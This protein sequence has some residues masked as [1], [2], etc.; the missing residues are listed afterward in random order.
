MSGFVISYKFNKIKDSDIIVKSSLKRYLRFSIP[1]VASYFIMYVSSIL[2]WGKSLP[3][4]DI[5]WEAIY[6]SEFCHEP[7]KNYALWTISFE[8]FGSFLIFSLLGIFGYSKNR[9]LFYFIVMAF[10][11]NTYYSFFVFG[12]ILSDLWA[13]K[14]I[15]H[16]KSRFVLFLCMLLSVFFIT[17]PFPR[18]GVHLGGIYNIITFSDDWS[19]NYSVYTKIGCFLLFFGILISNDL[20]KIFSSEITLFFGKISFPI[21]LIHASVLISIVSIYGKSSSFLCF[22]CMLFFSII[23]TILISIPFEIFIDRFGIKISNKFSDFLVE[24]KIKFFK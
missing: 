8:I 15:K 23:I 13:S 4:K 11:F 6:V 24:N 7:V 19:Y 10:L 18:D 5:M 1:I 14:R 3:F 21:Y 16:I 2:F 20:K 12:L 9:I 17:Y 22:L